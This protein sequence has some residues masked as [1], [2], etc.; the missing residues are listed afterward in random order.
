[1]NITITTTSRTCVTRSVRACLLLA[2]LALG[3]AALA[4]PPANPAS[5]NAP[6]TGPRAG[7]DLSTPEG[8]AAARDRLHHAARL[9]CTQVADTLAPSHQPNYGTCIDDA[10]AAA[11]RQVSP[12]NGRAP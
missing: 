10:L 8:A 11:V 4:G 7:Q 2:S 3:S 1:M 12:T 5:G 6:A 9:L